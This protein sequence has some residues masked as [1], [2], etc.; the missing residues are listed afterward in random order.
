M[1]RVFHMGPGVN[2]DEIIAGRHNLTTDREALGKHVFSEVRPDI[3]AEVKAGDVLVAGPNFGCGSSREHA[4]IAIA[5]AGFSCVVAPSF[6]R[7][8]YRNAINVGLPI[9]ICPEAYVS[10]AEGDSVEVDLHEGTITRSNG[11]TFQASPLP[12]FISRIVE[13]GG[14]VAYLRTSDLKGDDECA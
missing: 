8:F 5:G 1:A 2:T 9:L 10:L 4:P 7:I 14:L 3:A 12:E 6:A 11:D 13:A